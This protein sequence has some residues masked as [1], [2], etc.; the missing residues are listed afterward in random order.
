M[1]VRVSHLQPPSGFSLSEAALSHGWRSVRPYRWD[2]DRA[3][4]SRVDR[5]G[6]VSIEQRADGCLAIE[7]ASSDSRAL[8]RVRVVLDLR[9][10]LSE[11]HEA[12]A[13]HP[14]LDWVPK[15]GAGWV[16]RG[17][18]AW[19][20]AGK[21]ICF[22]NIAWRQAA[23]CID[24]LGEAAPGPFWPDPS[25]VLGL[26]ENWLRETVRVGYRAPYLIALAEGFETGRFSR[27]STQ[28]K[29]FQAMPGIGP[30]TAAYLAGM[31]GHWEEISFDSSIASLL[32]KRDGIVEPVAADAQKRYE[33][34]GA[35]AGLACLLDLHGWVR[36][37]SSTESTGSSC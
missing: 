2:G 11:F 21:A 36:G 16:L 6:A 31:W 14:T 10:D 29:E 5:E 24:R 26:G 12:C 34:F 35:L 22:T 7:H 1:S 13:G 4:L 30:S 27:E 15:K 18:D 33:P 20:D 9:T 28:R 23:R 37:L 8:E 19:E 17:L 32:R 25:D 3:V